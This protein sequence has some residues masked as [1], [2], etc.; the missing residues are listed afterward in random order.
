MSNSQNIIDVSIPFYILHFG[1]QHLIS[2]SFRSPKA[3]QLAK[4]RDRSRSIF[5]SELGL[6]ADGLGEIAFRV[7]NASFDEVDRAGSNSDIIPVRPMDNRLLSP[8]TTPVA[9]LRK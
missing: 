7:Q 8:T 3:R 4:L 2:S 9:S 1:E 6:N 5:R